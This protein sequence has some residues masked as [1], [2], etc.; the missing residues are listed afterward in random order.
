MGGPNLYVH[1]DND[2]AGMLEV[3]AW[4]GRR[5][6]EKMTIY[7]TYIL[8][9]NSITMCERCPNTKHEGAIL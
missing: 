8:D 4:P 7:R 1:D 3:E 9:N 6:G 2:R 5:S